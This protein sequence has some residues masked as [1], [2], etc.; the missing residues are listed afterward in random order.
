MILPA[1][2][3]AADGHQRYGTPPEP[4]NVTPMGVNSIPSGSPHVRPMGVHRTCGEP[5]EIK[6]NTHPK[7]VTALSRDQAFVEAQLGMTRELLTKYGNGTD[8][9][10][11]L[12]WDHYS[13]WV[14]GCSGDP[15]V[16]CTRREP[17]N[18][19]HMVNS[20]SP[21]HLHVRPM[22]VHRTCR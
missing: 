17:F 10:S 5:D 12:W 6:K 21:A 13:P 16:A 2:A 7:C 1:D 20:I 4:F 15:N 3:D 18:F 14:D 22:G 11:R 8:Y 9:V 19:T